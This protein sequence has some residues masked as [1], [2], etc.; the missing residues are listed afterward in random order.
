LK[1][2]LSKPEAQALSAQVCGGDSEAVQG[3]ERCERCPIVLIQLR[4]R[5]CHG[6][7]SVE[8]QPHF[9][10]RFWVRQVDEWPGL[11]P[12]HFNNVPTHKETRILF[13]CFHA[14]II[15]E[16]TNVR[17]ELHAAIRSVL[18]LLASA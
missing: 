4:P 9:S 11:P 12:A 17:T 14:D 10:T 6:E 13:L 16:D 15:P 18:P 2:D 5:R 8:I 1:A 7:V 3:F